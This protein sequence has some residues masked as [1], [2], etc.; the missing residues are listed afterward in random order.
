MTNANPFGD[1]SCTDLPDIPSTDAHKKTGR[2]AD[3]PR[4]PPALGVHWSISDGLNHNRPSND[5]DVRRTAPPDR[6]RTKQKTKR[7]SAAQ[8][9]TG[10]PPLDD[11]TSLRTRLDAA[12]VVSDAGWSNLDG[13]SDSAG[14]R[15]KKQRTD[16]L[17]RESVHLLLVSPK[18][19]V[20]EGETRKKK[21]NSRCVGGASRP[22]TGSATQMY[23]ID[24]VTECQFYRKRQP[25][26]ATSLGAAA[27]VLTD[28]R[29][30]RSLGK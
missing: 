12:F 10:R 7:A 14:W 20:T 23:V 22:G 4:K 13:F 26:T 8:K 24:R 2:R 18:V 6:R 25:A 1:S 17:P 9:E 19:Y 27:G 16:P 15:H 3:G 30:A 5:A 29:P 28:K 21:A 11:P